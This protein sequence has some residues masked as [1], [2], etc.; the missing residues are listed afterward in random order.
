MIHA[1]RT[2]T[3]RRTIAKTMASGQKAQEPGI[4]FSDVLNRVAQRENRRYRAQRSQ[5]ER[6]HESVAFA[7]PPA[8]SFQTIDSGQ[9]N[10]NDIKSRNEIRN[11]E[12]QSPQH[13]FIFL[14]PIRE[15]SRCS[16]HTVLLPISPNKHSACRLSTAHQPPA[17]TRGAAAR[18]LTTPGIPCRHNRI[19][20]RCGM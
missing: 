10:Q 19:P 18:P 11:P 14:N 7:R 6:R 20:R 13:K 17:I 4:M 9:H 15:N 16:I 8:S 1:T 12:A 3:L 2:A 5:H